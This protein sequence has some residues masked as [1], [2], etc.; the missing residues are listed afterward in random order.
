MNGR[1]RAERAFVQFHIFSRSK[2]YRFLLDFRK[3]Q[4]NDEA[5]FEGD[6]F[7][8]R[9]P[10]PCIVLEYKSKPRSTEK[11]EK[12]YLLIGWNKLSDN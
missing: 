7:L 9:K 3:K 4:K 1:F 2:E 11:H 12:A 6:F 8:K 5:T 10:S